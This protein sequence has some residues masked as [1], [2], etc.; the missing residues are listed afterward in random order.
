MRVRVMIPT[1]RRNRDTVV[2]IKYPVPKGYSSWTS[3]LVVFNA[4]LM[5]EILI[6]IMHIKFVFNSF[7]ILLLL[8]M[9]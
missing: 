3:S 7:S 2:V 4:D 6:K 9:F 1:H 5:R 8:V